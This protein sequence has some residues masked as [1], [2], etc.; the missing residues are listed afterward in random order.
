MLFHDNPSLLLV[1]RGKM[2]RLSGILNSP[3]NLSREFQTLS[4]V[5]RLRTSHEFLRLT[6]ESTTTSHYT[7][8]NFSISVSQTV[9]LINTAS[10][11]WIAIPLLELYHCC[12]SVFIFSKSAPSALSLENTTWQSSGRGPQVARSFPLES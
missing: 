9:L 6:S 1:E 7:I 10:S 11:F 2:G 4:E 12:S 3:N 5:S 8:Y